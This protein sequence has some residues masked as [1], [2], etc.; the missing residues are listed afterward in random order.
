M[1]RVVAVVQA[2][3]GS[4]R[5]P[6]KMLG[7]LGD[8][9]LL[10][11]VLERVCAAKKLDQTVLATSTEKLD[12]Q[13]AKIA[14]SLD[15]GV[16]RGSEDDV[17]SRFVQAIEET[18]ADLVVRVCADNPFVAAEEIDRL[19][20]A[21]ISGGFDYSCNHQQKLGNK[22]VDGVGAEIISADILMQISSSTPKQSHR[23]H[24][25]SFVWDNLSQ[26][27]V[28]ALVCPPN[29]A[30][31]E[32]RMDIDTSQDL[33]RLDEFVKNFAITTKS[34]AVEIVNAYRQFQNL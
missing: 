4:A 24:V 22:Y 10:S 12:D 1:S 26:F 15:V 16:V 7:Q 18:S 9:N 34:S 23:E 19:V 31:P 28:N 20:D 27:K 14:E 17:L 25:T 11:W 5:F 2:R 29:L 33:S 6:G 21:H 3:M 30:Y 8:Q 13:L 32:I